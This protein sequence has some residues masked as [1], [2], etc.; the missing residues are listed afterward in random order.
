V[1]SNV[2]SPKPDSRPHA[3]HG[4]LLTLRDGRQ[5]G[6]SEFG[7]PDGRPIIYCHGFPA[8]RLEMR[9]GHE[10]AARSGIRL[11]APDRPGYG[12]SDFQPGRR[13]SDWPR[14]VAELADALALRR[15]GVLGISGGGPYALA[16]AAVL[17][18]RVTVV[19]IVCGLGRLDVREATAGMSRFGR[20]S[21]ALTRRAPAASQILSRALAPVLRRSPQLILKLLASALPPPDAKVLSDPIVLGLL[22]DAF[23]EGLRQG[24]RGVALDLALYAQP[25][26]FAVESI[27]VPCHL[28]H[29]EQDRTVPVAMGKRLAAAI[30]G[31]CARFYPDEGHFS[32]PVRRMDEIL[33]VLG[34]YRTQVG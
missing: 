25:W 30:P 31:C 29:G 24:G 4:K 16:C 6:Y 34:V 17:P 9:L 18:N 1:I 19:G 8:S 23:R 12:L 28:W 10:V 13:I 33:T 21:F 2:V 27:R 20:L 15:F 3:S 7:A 14:D 32:L 11:I 26:E 22:A 5:L